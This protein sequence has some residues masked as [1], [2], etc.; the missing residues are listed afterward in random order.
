MLGGLFELPRRR[1]GL[2]PV[3]ELPPAEAAEE[4]VQEVA[5][6]D[7]ALVGIRAHPATPADEAIAI[8]DMGYRYPGSVDWALRGVNLRIPRGSRVGGLVGST[9]SGKTTLALIISG[10]MHPS[11][12]SISRRHYGDGV[13][14]RVAIV[15]QDVYLAPD[16]V[17][18]NV[19]LPFDNAEVQDAEVWA[20]LEDA[21]VADVVRRF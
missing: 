20:A 5:T 16:T 15:P 21:Q 11:E 4:P 14:A 13:G 10:L 6:D 17:R 7:R 8:E 9:G 3:L 18:V 2:A 1:R 12:G 19:A